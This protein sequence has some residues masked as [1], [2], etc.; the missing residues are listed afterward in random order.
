MR[1]VKH[2]RKRRNHKLQEAVQHTTDVASVGTKVAQ[3]SWLLL[4]KEMRHRLKVHVRPARPL[5]VACTCGWA[6]GVAH[7]APPPGTCVAGAALQGT[8][9][10]RVQV[11][12]FR[13][14][15]CVVWCFNHDLMTAAVDDLIRCASV[16]APK[17][18]NASP[19]REMCECLT[20]CTRPP[21]HRRY[22]AWTPALAFTANLASAGVFCWGWLMSAVPP[23]RLQV[24]S[25]VCASWIWT[26][27]QGYGLF[28]GEAVRMVRTERGR[29]VE[30]ANKRKLFDPPAQPSSVE[31]RHR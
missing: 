29:G 20:R 4:L 10:H 22:I 12:L 9:E 14:A 18:G 6:R 7:P 1:R 17:R 19:P 21:P 16:Q 24:L 15:A 5:P 13:A 27:R 31:V 2:L 30:P 11:Q 26:V 25:E 28:S 8:F 3:D 23:K